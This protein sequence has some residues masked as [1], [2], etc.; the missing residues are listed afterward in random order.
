LLD[1]RIAALATVDLDTFADMLDLF[2]KAQN[3]YLCKLYP[4]PNSTETQRPK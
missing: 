3:E 4:P 2:A 1:A